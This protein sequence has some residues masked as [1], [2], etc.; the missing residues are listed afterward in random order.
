M[1]GTRRRGLPSRADQEVACKVASSIKAGRAQR[2]L[3]C[4]LADGAVS[5]LA[6]AATSGVLERLEDTYW[7]SNFWCKW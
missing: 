1:G 5:G 4:R 2:A 7:S 3:E 6:S